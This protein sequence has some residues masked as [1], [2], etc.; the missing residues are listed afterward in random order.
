MK[1]KLGRATSILVGLALVVLIMLIVLPGGARDADPDAPT[2]T[3][4]PSDAAPVTQPPGGDTAP[5]VTGDEPEASIA[6]TDPTDA[7]PTATPPDTPIASAPPDSP[8][9]PSYAPATGRR[10]AV[11]APYARESFELTIDPDAFDEIAEGMSTSF[12]YKEAGNY[13]VFLEFAFMEGTV[14]GLAPDFLK[15]YIPGAADS[16]Q[17]L[18]GRISASD[19]AG[20]V[21]RAEDSTHSVDAWLVEVTGG[22]MAIVVSY[23]T[24]AQRDTLYAILDSLTLTK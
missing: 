7:P 11:I 16:T 4:S 6:P 10:A 9:T 17:F 14:D 21:L 8:T 15:N 19:V 12:M 1:E 13:R 18:L 24:D 3:P 22:L 20:V 2:A 23:E 5:D